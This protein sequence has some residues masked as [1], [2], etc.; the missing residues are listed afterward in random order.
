LLHGTQRASGLRKFIEKFKLASQGKTD[1]LVAIAPR[2]LRMRGLT[3][4]SLGIAALSR[5]LLVDPETASA[6]PISTTP[7]V[8]GVPATVRPMLASAE[9]L[10]SWF[11]GLSLYE[12]ALLLQ[13][14]L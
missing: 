1:L 8:A 13:V 7:A 2:A 10:G 12:I 14:R 6:V 11:A 9:K 3:A 4:Q 5:L